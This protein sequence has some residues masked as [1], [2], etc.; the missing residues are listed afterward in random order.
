VSG[1]WLPL[2]VVLLLTALPVRLLAQTSADRLAEARAVRDGGQHAEALRLYR[3]LLD[4]PD[5]EVRAVALEGAALILSWQGQYD[6]A[7]AYYRELAE[8][9]PAKRREAIYGAARTLGWAGR[10]GEGLRELQPLLEAHPDD[11]AIRL[12][13]AQVSGWGGFTSRSV[14]AFHKVIELDPGANEARL[15]LAKVLAWGG[16]LAESQKEFEDL[17]DRV[18]TYDAARVGIAYTLLWQGRPHHA[19][20]HFDLITPA[21]RESKE[22]KI[23]RVALEWAL[24]ERADSVAHL[25][26]LMRELPGEPDVRDLWRSQAGVIGHN[27]RGDATY[28]RDNGGLA[29]TSASLGGALRL[30]HP[31]FLFGDYRQEWLR[32]DAVAGGLAQDD[33]GVHGGRMGLDWSFGRVALRGSLGARKSTV[34]TGGAV[35]GLGMRTLVRPNLGV[36]L[37]L[38]SDFAFFT[39]KAVR[40]DVRMTGLGVGI[41]KALTA[42]LGL[43]TGYSR[44]H[45]EGPDGRVRVTS[46]ADGERKAVDQN[47]DLVHAALRFQAGGFGGDHGNVRVDL[48]AR[49]TYF[50]FDRQYPDLGYWNPRDFRQGMGLLGATYRKGEKLTLIANASLG[51]QKQD[52]QEWEVAAYLYAEGLRQMG[53]RADLWVR[54]DYGSSGFSRRP[55]VATGYRAWTVAAGFLVRVGDRSPRPEMSG[56]PGQPDPRP[57]NPLSPTNP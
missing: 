24:M 12:L 52:D 23:L 21:A 2:T 56:G 15:G 55:D 34:D 4:D 54:A 20:R 16:R 44:T 43:T 30:H 10:H 28:L 45:F 11:Q 32:Q 8:T 31:A 22:Y 29:V 18:P 40:R 3:V 51:M 36:S 13:E 35:L 38:D 47:R 26:S 48:G 42:R 17:L 6:D 25:R 5:P 14:R 37:N 19:K 41:S 39:P 7:I 53:R 33:V 49:G 57:V 46:P 27:V 1:A 9:S 50:R